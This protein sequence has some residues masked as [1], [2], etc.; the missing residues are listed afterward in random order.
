VLDLQLVN[1]F[2]CYGCPLMPHQV[3]S[4]ALRAHPKVRRSAA[5]DCTPFPHSRIVCPSKKPSEI[6]VPARCGGR[7]LQKEEMRPR[8]PKRSREAGFSAIDVRY[9]SPEQLLQVR[10]Y[11]SESTV[12]FTFSS[13]HSVS[14][15]RS[16]SASNA[17]R[18]SRNTAS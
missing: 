7:G 16:T 3:L 1:L 18:S 13:E 10:V 6:R 4:V 8:W 12:D 5:I 17:L 11:V 2:R 15:K 9:R 14:A